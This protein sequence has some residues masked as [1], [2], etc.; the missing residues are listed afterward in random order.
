MEKT[1][2]IK[3]IPA[4]FLFIRILQGIAMLNRQATKEL[5]TILFSILGGFMASLAAVSF[6]LRDIQSKQQREFWSRVFKPGRMEP[7]WWFNLVVSVPF[8]ILLGVWL[9]ALQGGHTGQHC[10][11]GH[12]SR[13]G[14]GGVG[15]DVYPVTAYQGI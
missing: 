14:I 10:G 12:L 1:V 3:F 5:P 13:Y 11:I 2:P 8:T 9:K 15:D 4:T 7:F 6:V